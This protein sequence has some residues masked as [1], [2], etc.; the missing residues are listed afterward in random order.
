VVDNLYSGISLSSGLRTCA[1]GPAITDRPN[2]FWTSGLAYKKR[3]VDLR[4]QRSGPKPASVWLRAA[5]LVI[6]VAWPPNQVDK[7]RSELLYAMPRPSSYDCSI[8]TQ[9]AN[10]T[11]QLV[12]FLSR[13]VSFGRLLFLTAAYPVCAY[14]VSCRRSVLLRAME[15]CSRVK[16][17]PWLGLASTRPLLA[18]WFKDVF[19]DKSW[20][21]PHYYRKHK[22]S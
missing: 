15:A 11:V 7:Q 16:A 12:S 20:V 4:N 6:A 10:D 5:M 17:R 18:V 3:T 22:R 8:R 9:N 19:G 14:I 21:A 13:Y 1:N 2:R